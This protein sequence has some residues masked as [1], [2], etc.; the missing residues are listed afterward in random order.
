MGYWGPRVVDNDDAMDW[1]ESLPR[2]KAKAEVV[3]ALDIFVSMKDPAVDTAQD[4]SLWP[5]EVFKYARACASA[6][7]AAEAIAGHFGLG[8]ANAPSEYK[9]IKWGRSAGEEDESFR[10]LAIRVTDR[11]SASHLMKIYLTG[12]ANYQAWRSGVQ[13]L[14]E[15]LGRAQT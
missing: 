1:V 5:P 6:L 2:T 3:S 7:A 11:A 8:C 13:D 15:R 9:R 12:Y 14:H 4:P 10:S